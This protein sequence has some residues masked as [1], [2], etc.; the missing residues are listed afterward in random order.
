MVVGSGSN[1][2]SLLRRMSITPSIWYVRQ[3]L[4]VFVLFRVLW[5]LV[6]YGVGEGCE[7]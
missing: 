4:I 5:E 3:F 1:S 7:Q 2:Q 6:L